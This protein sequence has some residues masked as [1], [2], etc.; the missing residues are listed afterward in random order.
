MEPGRW[1]SSPI[2]VPVFRICR[3]CSIL[4]PRARPVPRRPP[5]WEVP[6]RAVASL[7]LELDDDV[8][9]DLDDRE[10]ILFPP[11][12]SMDKESEEEGR[13]RDEE[14]DG[15]GEG[16]WALDSSV[17][18]CLYRVFKSD[19]SLRVHREGDRNNST[20]LFLF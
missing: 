19:I 9:D 3:S 5:R 16:R 8:L 14:G 18:R 20:R 13:M 17:L 6:G 12:S 1:D 15:A 4:W 11:S 10:R 2:S 7:E